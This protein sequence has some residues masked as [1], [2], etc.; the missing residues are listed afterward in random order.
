MFYWLWALFATNYIALRRFCEAPG[1]RQ[2][3]SNLCY[4][5]DLCTVNMVEVSVVKMYVKNRGKK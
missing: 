1:F 2:F 4:V 3:S 5:I